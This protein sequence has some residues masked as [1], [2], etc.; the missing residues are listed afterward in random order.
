[1]RAMVEHE[2]DVMRLSCACLAAPLVVSTTDRAWKDREARRWM[3]RHRG[4]A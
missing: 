4:C 3:R 1:M 2:G